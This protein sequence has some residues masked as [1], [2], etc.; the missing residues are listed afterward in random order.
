MAD[1]KRDLLFL[2]DGSNNIAGRF[3]AVRDFVASIIDGLDVSPDGTRVG[4]GLVG[5]NVKVEFKFDSYATKADV[6]SAVRKMKYKPSKEFKLGVA[7]DYAY[8]SLFT[9]ES[10]SRIREG[11]PQYLV[12]LAAGKSSDSVDNAANRLK[13]AGI[14]TFA[15]KTQRA[16]AEELEKIVL[17]PQFVLASE[18]IADLSTIQSQFVNLIKTISVELPTQPCK[19]SASLVILAKNTKSAQKEKKETYE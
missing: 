18:S 16:E 14:V 3:P 5:E 4:V 11:V 19:Y 10:G 15:V 1:S 13:A 6:I 8:D 2:I 12:L 7:L 17:A 9:P